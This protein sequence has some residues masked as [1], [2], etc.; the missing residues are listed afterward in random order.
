MIN[1]RYE[2]FAFVCSAPTS[3][4]HLTTARKKAEAIQEANDMCARI[5]AHSDAYYGYG[6]DIIVA[7][8]DRMAPAY[9]SH[10]VY[11]RVALR[12]KGDRK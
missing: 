5:A 12:Q 1:T 8:N 3:G 9:R 10:F 4:I 11:R 7:V 2:I 6:E